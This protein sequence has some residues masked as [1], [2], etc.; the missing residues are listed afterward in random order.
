MKSLSDGVMQE[1][2]KECQADLAFAS[3]QLGLIYFI[4]K[5][6]GEAE[7]LL[8]TSLEIHSKLYGERNSS[9]VDILV[10]VGNIYTETYRLVEGEHM[11][12]KAIEITKELP[13]MHQYLP[14]LEFKLKVNREMQ[15]RSR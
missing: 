9:V 4:Q 10:A 1:M 12:L 3:K 14:Q 8:L 15:L 5:R 2:A 11:Y 7:P 6:F 13:D